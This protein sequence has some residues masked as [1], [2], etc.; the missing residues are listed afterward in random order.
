VGHFYTPRNNAERF[1]A[2][3]AKNPNPKIAAK[4]AGVVDAAGRWTGELSMYFA[5]CFSGLPRKGKRVFVGS[6]TD[7]F[8]RRI[9]F[10]TL[11]MIFAGFAY[12][13]QHTFM[14]LTKRPD[15]AYLFLSDNFAKPLPNVWL[16]VAVCNQAEADEKIP[17]LLDT[18]AAKRFV[19]VEP[20]L[21]PVDIRKYL[22]GCYEC[23]LS[24]GKRM[25]FT[26]SPEKQCLGCGFI[27]ADDHATWGNGEFEE[28]PQCHGDAE[29]E[30]V[31]PDC[32]TYMATEHP[33]TP[34][35]DWVICGAETGPGKRRM[36]TEWALSLRDQCRS[37]FSKTPFFFK[38][39]SAGVLLL[40]GREWNEVPV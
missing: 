20:M 33:D 37:H 11:R 3:H 27:G 28:C 2:R 30:Q 24:C 26:E 7:M 9:H 16:G 18:P 34:N 12:H 21:G 14:L 25:S 40:D 29:V 17:V 22:Y 4:Y 10:H 15:K 5:D 36:E 6:M 8:H 23:A 31:C 35:I 38:K 39:D 32:G 13:K 19:I 1:A